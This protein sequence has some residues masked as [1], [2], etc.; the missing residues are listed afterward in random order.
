[1]TIKKKNKNKKKLRQPGE[2]HFFSFS[3]IAHISEPTIVHQILS[4][5][6]NIFDLPF[7]APPY[8]YA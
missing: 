3:Q 5:F 1:M 4:C 8:L 7:A 2:E 6:W